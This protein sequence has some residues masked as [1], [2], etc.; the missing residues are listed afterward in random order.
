MV[1]DVVRLKVGPVN[2]NIESGS[3]VIVLLYLSVSDCSV[4][5]VERSKKGSGKADSELHFIEPDFVYASM[6]FV[7]TSDVVLVVV[8]VTKVV[9]VV[10]EV[11]IVLLVVED[12]KG[13]TFLVVTI[14]L[15]GAMSSRNGSSGA[16][17]VVDA[18]L[19][20]S[21]ETDED[22]VVEELPMSWSMAYHVNSWFLS[23]ALV[24]AASS[25]RMGSMRSGLM[26][27]DSRETTLPLPRMMDGGTWGRGWRLSMKTL[28]VSL[29]A[30]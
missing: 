28:L 5:V 1:V 20:E 11:F 27:R 16:G 25:T 17:V 24:D 13:S 22:V 29:A 2:K 15:M 6:L 30:V 3:Q 19:A 18:F 4:L 9:E 21:D 7:V 8:L 14:L 12:G 23:G 10:V 26:E